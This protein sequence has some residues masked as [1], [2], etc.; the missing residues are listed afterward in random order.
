MRK[1]RRLDTDSYLQPLD[2]TD[3]D[4]SNELWIA[5][6]DTDER[7]AQLALRIWDDNGLDVKEDVLPQLLGSLGK[8]NYVYALHSFANISMLGH[9]SAFVRTSAAIAIAE[10]VGQTPDSAASAVE[11]LAAAY[12]SAAK[13]KMPVYDQFGMLIEESLHQQ[14]PW[15]ERVAIAETFGHLAALL[16]ASEV[17]SFFHLL[18][19][20]QALGDRSEAVRSKMLEVSLHEYSSSRYDAMTYD[21]HIDRLE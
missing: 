7:N 11:Q 13:E 8:H 18:I 14:D 10:A 1:A 2:L 16:H 5:V 21:V 3:M 15:Q 19:D 20:E 9:S 17:V 12:K 6:Q 4:Y